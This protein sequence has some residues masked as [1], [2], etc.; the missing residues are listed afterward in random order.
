MRPDLTSTPR[1]GSKKILL[2]TTLQYPRGR[3]PHQCQ[4]HGC[5]IRF[6]TKES[7]QRHYN[8]HTG[9]RPYKCAYDGC[10]ER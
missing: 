5:N 6:K 1:R 2:G 4:Y 3:E 7:M 10:L 8:T 9:K